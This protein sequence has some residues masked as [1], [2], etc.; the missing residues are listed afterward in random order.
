MYC[1][2]FLQFFAALW[3]PTNPFLL[4]TLSR[5]DRKQGWLAI[6]REWILEVFN[7]ICG[8]FTLH[9]S[10]WI[11]APER[12]GKHRWVCQLLKRKLGQLHCTDVSIIPPWLSANCIEHD[13]I[14]TCRF[15][16]YL[17]KLI[18]FGWILTPHLSSSSVSK[19]FSKCRSCT[20]IHR[21]LYLRRDNSPS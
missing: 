2:I 4:F 14:Y 7:Y 18:I 6:S 11:L 9:A 21:G 3:D 20:I 19:T 1:Y 10:S 13:T 8:H 12:T 5:E 17:N 16:I 15:D